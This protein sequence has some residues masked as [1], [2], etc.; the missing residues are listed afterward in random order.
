MLAVVLIL[1]VV[2]IFDQENRLEVGLNT[3]FKNPTHAIETHRK[4]SQSKD[5]Q[6]REESRKV[7]YGIRYRIALGKN[8]RTDRISVNKQRFGQ[9]EKFNEIPQNKKLYSFPRVFSS[10]KKRMG[11]AET[12]KRMHASISQ[13]RLLRNPEILNKNYSSKSAYLLKTK[14]MNRIEKQLEGD[15]SS[16]NTHQR[17]AENI[18]KLISFLKQYNSKRKQILETNRNIFD[19]YNNPT[20]VPQMRKTFPKM[21]WALG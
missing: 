14:I 11:L 20:N 19:K 18:R 16:G 3:Q 9:Q 15:T 13:N 1:S 7:L 10:S 2:F 5:D 4:Q 6:L 17:K 8:D 12:L 21:K